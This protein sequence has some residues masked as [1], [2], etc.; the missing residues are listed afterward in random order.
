VIWRTTR[1]SRGAIAR[2]WFDQEGVDAIVD[3]AKFGVALAASQI[4][5]DKVFLGSGAATSDLTGRARSP[6]TV[7]CTYDSFAL[8]H[9]TSGA[10][11]A[12]GESWF[13]LTADHAFGQALERD[14]SA[15][16]VAQGGKVAG[17]VKHPLNTS[18]FFSK[19][20][21]IGLA[22][23]KRRHDQRGQAGAR[24]RQITNEARSAVV[25]RHRCAQ[26][27]PQGGPSTCAPSS[28]SEV[29]EALGERQGRRLPF[30]RS[31][32]GC[33]RLTVVRRRCSA[34]R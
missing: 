13:F 26:P 8:S 21:V 27:R 4:A 2:K 28:R 23:A 34:L 33:S 5:K 12:G 30:F 14:T 6:N 16:V 25:L 31:R 18:H 3:A 15:V 24:V 22:N 17:S 11:V 7:H 9:G 10:L 20:K 32:R 29:H 1:T 19:T